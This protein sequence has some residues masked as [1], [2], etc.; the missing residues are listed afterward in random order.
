MNF[1]FTMEEEEL[2]EMLSSLSEEARQ[3]VFE[4]LKEKFS[5]KHSNSVQLMF[6]F[7]WLSIHPE[8]MGKIKDYVVSKLREEFNK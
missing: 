7:Y 2:F 6:E 3:S 8:Q 4:M 5:E 1:D